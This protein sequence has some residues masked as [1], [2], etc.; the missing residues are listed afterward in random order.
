MEGLQEKSQSVL[1]KK[2]ERGD[3]YRSKFRQEQRKV[4]RTK[5]NLQKARIKGNKTQIELDRITKEL[6]VEQMAHQHAMEQLA[7]QSQ[8]ATV[9]KTKLDRKADAHR[10]MVARF[11][12]RKKLAIEQ[13]VHEAHTVYLKKGKTVSDHTRETIRELVASGVPVKQV[14]PTID[15]VSRGLGVETKGSFSVRTSS[16]AVGEGGVASR[17]QLAHEIL[18]TDCELTSKNHTTF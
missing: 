3:L 14:G 4:L 2:Q 9:L 6:A 13:A 12:S 7:E 10:K 5:A 15:I 8:M 16:R 17:W 1:R 18:S 11:A